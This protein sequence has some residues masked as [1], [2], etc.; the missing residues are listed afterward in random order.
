MR[1]HFTKQ[2]LLIFNS[3]DSRYSWYFLIITYALSFAY[4][5]FF[6]RKYK[7][8][9]WADAFHPKNFFNL[10]AWVDIVIFTLAGLAAI[11]YFTGIDPDVVYAFGRNLG[12]Y[13]YQ[14][15]FPGGADLLII[16]IIWP[17]LRMVV[18]DF[19]YYLYHFIMH[20]FTSLWLFHAVHHSARRLN[21]LT[22]YRMHPVDGFMSNL[23][24]GLAG[25]IFGAVTVLLFG[26]GSIT[27]IIYGFLYY[28]PLRAGIANLRHSHVWMIFPDW[29][30]L[31]VMSPAHH[32]IHHSRSPEHVNINYSNDFAF[33]DRMFGTLHVPRET[34]NESFEIGIDEEVYQM[35]A[36]SAISCLFV[37]FLNLYK[38]WK[39]RLFG[40]TSP[41]WIRSE[42]MV[43]ADAS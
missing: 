40:G 3:T 39:Y 23:I 4:Y 14:G 16:K 34:E 7:S 38:H 35:N 13:E 5:F 37:P 26:V 27:L 6:R 2:F 32:Q 1:E 15:L 9:I 41:R 18:G 30:A 36:G 33:I 31:L 22:A 11:K 12:K 10:S 19:A 21:L 25:G 17:L 24:L 8:S 42:A 43:K 20:R 29:L 28:M